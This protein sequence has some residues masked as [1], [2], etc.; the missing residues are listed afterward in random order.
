VQV[1]EGKG[2][3]QR[4][5]GEVV[6]RGRIP[7]WA[8]LVLLF[9]CV[10]L[11]IAGITAINQ[12]GK[13]NVKK[14]ATVVA[15]AATATEQ[16][17]ESVSIDIQVAPAEITEMGS[18]KLAWNIGNAKQVRLDGAVVPAQGEETR[19][20]NKTTTYTWTIVKLNDA[21]VTETRTVEVIAL[22]SAIDHY[23]GLWTTVNRQP[24]QISYILTDLHISLDNA[25]TA[26]LRGCWSRPRTSDWTWHL[27]PD[28]VVADLENSK[29]VAKHPFVIDSLEW[30]ITALRS[31]TGLKAIVEQ[32][33]GPSGSGC[34]SQTFVMEKPKSS[35]L[36]AGTNFLYCTGPGN[37]IKVFP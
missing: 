32:C 24:G 9:L 36:Y 17:Q 6:S 33:S 35:L 15:M 5:S 10:T 25:T 20:P 37:S 19:H 30:T 13:Q 27:E 12:V 23:A 28:R 11:A 14:T 26:T 34:R 21:Q 22:G 2:E 31:G 1:S 7:V 18:T 29:L 3:A 8:P 16:A 4:H